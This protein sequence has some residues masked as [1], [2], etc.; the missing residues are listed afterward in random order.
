LEQSIALHDPQQHHSLALAYGVDPRVAFLSHTAFAL[1]KLGYPDQAL[2]RGDEMLVVA[3]EATQPYGLA[4]ALTWAAGL[5][6]LCQEV[7]AT[8]EQAE[9]AIALS[10]EQGFPWLLAA[11]IIFR[12][13][14]LAEQGQG[15]EGI[16][17]IR[18]GMTAFRATGAEGGWPIYLACLAGAYSKVGQAE[19]GL[20]ALAEALGFVHKTGGC[21][22]EA[23]LYR[24]KGQLTLQKLSVV[25]P[26]LSVT[27][28]Q[29]LIPNPP[30]EAEA[31]FLKAIDIAHRQQAKSLELRAAM[32][33]ARL[34]R[35][36]GKTAEAHHLLSE[37]YGWFAEG[38][39]TKDL[40]EAK[41]L[42]QELND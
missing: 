4:A 40:Q 27:N 13:W 8:R 25:S 33:L 34:W 15:E 39:D 30:T 32:S 16:A 22:N 28:P 38:F 41:A 18:Q 37:I 11:V 1:W 19:E 24:L 12:G 31:C 10:S 7:Q 29:P 21:H 3:Q 6:M 9:M 17:Q 36:Q 5:H 2:K 26:Q 35:Q 23:E 20:S 14:A 42:L